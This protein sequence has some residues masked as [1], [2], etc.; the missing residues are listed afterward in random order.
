MLPM[1]ISSSSE[2]PESLLA[3]ELELEVELD[4]E[5]ED[6]TYAR[7]LDLRFCAIYV[8]GSF[9]RACRSSSFFFRH[10]LLSLML[11]FCQEL[12]IR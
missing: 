3:I 6:E 12:F 7:D 11:S 9:G 5:L 10:D 4:A 8:C 1:P 2:E